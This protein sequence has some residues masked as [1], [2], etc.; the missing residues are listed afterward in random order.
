[1]TRALLT[2]SFDPVTVG[3]LDLIARGSEMYEHLTVGMFLNPDKTY[4]FSPKERVALLKAACAFANVDVVVS[5]GYV[6]DLAREGGYTAI[7]RGIRSDADLAY[8][9][10]MAEYNFLHSGVETVMLDTDPALAHIS[11]SLVRNTIREGGDWT[12]LVPPACVALIDTFLKEKK[13][14]S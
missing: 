7:L 1:M 13:K 14:F 9:A 5:E 3:H 4:F 6:A 2:G 11:S 10:P 8:E 12:S